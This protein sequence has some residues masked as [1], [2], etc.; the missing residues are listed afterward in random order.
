MNPRPLI[1]LSQVCLSRRS[2]CELLSCTKTG[3]LP[4][5]N[6]DVHESSAAAPNMVE[7]AGGLLN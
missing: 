6:D 1:I 3:S 2:S 4:F 7:N 5:I